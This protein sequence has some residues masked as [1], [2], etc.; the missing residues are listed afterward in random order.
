MIEIACKPY[1]S[2]QPSRLEAGTE[3]S[4]TVDTLERFRKE[5][6]PEDELFFLI[7]ADAF[8]EVTTWKQWQTVATLTEFVV[9]SRPGITYELPEGVRVHRL[10]SLD[11]SV[12]SSGVRQ[13]LARGETV[14]E[15]PVEVRE[16]I[17]GRGLYGFH[18]GAAAT[19]A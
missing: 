16:Y 18:D 6:L 7:G 14:P 4:Y 1:P 19:T 2:F 12:S 9:V 17:E 8:A 10:D 5:L 15:V 11:L 3:P 13:R